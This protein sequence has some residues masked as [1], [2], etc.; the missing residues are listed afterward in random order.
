MDKTSRA[1]RIKLL[2]VSKLVSKGKLGYFLYTAVHNRDL[3]FVLSKLPHHFSYKV[4]N[5]IFA[6]S[7]KRLTLFCKVVVLYPSF[8]IIWPMEL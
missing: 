6:N 8:Y 5:C 3:T 2:S 1:V 7:L 4:T